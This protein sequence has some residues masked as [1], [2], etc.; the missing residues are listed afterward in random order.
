MYSKEKIFTILKNCAREYPEELI[1]RELFDV[2]RIAFNISLVL[3]RTVGD[4]RICDLGGGIGLF[5]VGC[6]AVGMSSILVDDFR[7]DVNTEFEAVPR[8][9]HKKHN[10]EVVSTDV[11]ETPP[12][13]ANESLDVVTSFDSFEHW[14]HS[15][16]SLFQKVMKWLKPNGL[17]IIG[18]PNC[19]NL[20]KR[21][22]VPFGYG[23]WSQM[24]DWY[25][26]DRFRGHVREPDVADL[27]YIGENLGLIDIEILGRNWLGYSSRFSLVRMM[28]PFIDR[29]LRLFP[30]LCSDL[31]LIGRKPS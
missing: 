24:E 22:T 25:E 2:P 8:T 4:V 18:M 17:F 21:I 11:I 30:S 9:V 7:D 15:P 19:V 27:R 31:Y 5:S 29:P 14:H 16:K 12:A 20:R 1:G 10:V 3:Q 6:A 13:F 28:T 23:K 26:P